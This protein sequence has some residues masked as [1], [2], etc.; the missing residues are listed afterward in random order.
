MYPCSLF[1]PLKQ[2]LPEMWMRSMRYYERYMAAIAT[3]RLYD[4]NGVEHLCID[5]Q[6]LCRLLTK[7]ITKI[8]EFKVI[9]T[10]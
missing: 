7:L 4:E 5:E 9:R 2:H 1:P 3:G 10:V 8:I 6:K